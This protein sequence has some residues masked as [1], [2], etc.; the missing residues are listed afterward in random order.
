[1]TISTP[2]LLWT[3]I[4][5]LVPL[6]IIVA[7]ISASRKRQIDDR[8]T[9][10]QVATFV[11]EFN[12]KIFKLIQQI[13]NEGEFPAILSQISEISRACKNIQVEWTIWVK[14]A[15]EDLLSL[16]YE[17]VF[18]DEK[19]RVENI[20]TVMYAISV[21]KVGSNQQFVDPWQPLQQYLKTLS[22]DD[23]LTVYATVIK[24][25]FVAKQYQ[26]HTVS[27]LLLKA[28]KNEDIF[29]NRKFA[30]M[31]IESLKTMAAE[32]RDE[33]KASYFNA[34]IGIVEEVFNEA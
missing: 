16:Y 2:E 27:R 31:A 20:A 1:M 23:K 34:E 15:I 8:D 30:D 29:K 26:S 7:L 4:G 3:V 25:A 28:V 17:R 12:T 32:V 24:T 11:L 5:L 19:E 14:T 13:N 9:K 18:A 22:A 10:L 33:A 6:I 21:F